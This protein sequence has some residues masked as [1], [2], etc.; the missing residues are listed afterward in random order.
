MGPEGL[1]RGWALSGEILP[2][3]GSLWI[4]REER[5]LG[6]HTSSW[7]EMCEGGAKS[8]ETVSDCGILELGRQTALECGQVIWLL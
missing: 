3:S 1:D 7:E 5:E 2:A 6:Q 8:Q 4:H